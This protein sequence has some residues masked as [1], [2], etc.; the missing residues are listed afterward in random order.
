MRFLN[1]LFKNDYHEILDSF[2]INSLTNGCAMK[3]RLTLLFVSLFL[4]H[5][6]FGE[7]PATGNQAPEVSKGDWAKKLTADH[8]KF[9]DLKQE[10]EYA[11]DVT[12][13][14]LKCHT[15]AGKQIHKTFHWNWRTKLP[16]GTVMGKGEGAFNTFC[17]NAV[18]S[19]VSCAACHIGYGYSNPDFDF[20]DETAIDCLVCHD[21][22]GT[23]QKHP[24]QAGH[25]VYENS[26]DLKKVNLSFVAQNVGKS[27]RHNCLA[28]H[29]NGGGG[30]GT[31][32]GDTDMSLVNPPK[33]LDVHMSPEGLNFSCQD[34]HTVSEHK[35]AGRYFGEPAFTD[36]KKNMGR[37]DR[38]GNTITC[39]GCHG[40]KPHH[41]SRLNNHTNKVACATCHIPRMAR[42]GYATNMTWDWSTGG[43]NTEGKWLKDEGGTPLYEHGHPIDHLTG[44][45]DPNIEVPTYKAIK[46]TFTWATNVVPEY[47]WYKGELN[48][49]SYKDKIDPTQPVLVN[50]PT[51][52]YD[53]KMAKI[54][55]FKI[56]HTKQPYDK[57]FN[58]IL[59]PFLASEKGSGAF[60]MDFDWDASLK[61][62]SEFTGV[63][64]SGEYG[65]A[66]TRSFW[67]IKHM[68]APEEQS[69]S[70]KECHSRNGRL[71]KLEGFY[72]VGRDS[73]RFLD[74]LGA[75][76]IFG[77]LFGV[78]GHGILRVVSKKKD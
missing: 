55:P 33:E 57:K 49:M 62:G 75:L 52:D 41:D 28:C 38:E 30:N 3:K 32:H 43:K 42:G 4:S 34:C 23:Y 9:E 37:R 31:K 6:L 76:M 12:A 65:F 73:S 10:F 25:P 39:Q 56:H 48:Q 26:G 1:C 24:S 7:G 66:D 36:Y 74:I 59:P 70:C 2:D 19:E 60:W 61:K 64:F 13:A 18:G 54:W 27:Q 15:E 16:D 14:C 45:E 72:L 44:K 29:A 22:T 20:T 78:I 46:G 69:V 50:P 40:E 5:C 77:A 63:P 71:D 11:P 67:V 53:D 35:I 47:L 58:T 8:S 68:V 51:G 17:V 21:T